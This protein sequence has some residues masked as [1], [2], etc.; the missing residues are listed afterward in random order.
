MKDR[1]LTRKVGAHRCM[2]N[3]EGFQQ[4]IT[5]ETPY[6][7]R[8]DV[9]ISPHQHCLNHI[10]RAATQPSHLSS[11]GGIHLTLDK[12]H[13]N[14]PQTTFRIP[15]STWTSSVLRI[16]VDA[17][18]YTAI[19]DLLARANDQNAKAILPSINPAD[20]HSARRT[21]SH[22]ITPSPGKYQNTST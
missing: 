18:H 7:A 3:C 1:R 14:Y 16:N 11:T 5:R 10:L 9:I 8:A 15:G 17:Y 4:H 13:R 6:I 2:V 19:Q 22:C 12:P 21:W 20:T